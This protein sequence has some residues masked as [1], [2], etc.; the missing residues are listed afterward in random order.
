MSDSHNSKR[1]MTPFTSHVRCSV[2]LHVSWWLK[3]ISHMTLLR[4]GNTCCWLADLIQQTPRTARSM[5]C[6]CILLKCKSSW[7]VSFGNRNFSNI[8]P[9]YWNNLPKEIRD[10]DMY[11]VTH[12]DT[13]GLYQKIYLFTEAFQGS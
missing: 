6:L 8:A 11:T 4:L 3:V 12:C 1:A 5:T 13:K 9:K 2:L 7:S 10:C